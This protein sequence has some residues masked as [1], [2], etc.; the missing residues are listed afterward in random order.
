MRGGEKK[1]LR[2]KWAQELKRHFRLMKNK[3]DGIKEH[4]KNKQY[5]GL[6]LTFV[7][8]MRY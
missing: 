8:V 2:G 5:P 7:A 6:L 4:K 1:H 3:N